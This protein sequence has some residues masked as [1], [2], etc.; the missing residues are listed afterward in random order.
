MWK[1]YFNNFL[2]LYIPLLL[3]SLLMLIGQRR[4]RIADFVAKEALV[5]MQKTTFLSDVCHYLIHNI[6]YWSG[7]VYPVGFETNEGHA[8]FIHPYIEVIK[9]I[10]FYDQFR[11]IDLSGEERLR[12]QSNFGRKMELSSLQNKVDSDYVLRGLNLKKGEVYLSR[13]NLNRENN[14]IERP[15][16][17]VLRAVAPIYDSL[18]TKVGLVVINFRVKD[19][20]DYLTKFPQYGK[21][22]LVDSELNVVASSMGGDLPPYEVRDNTEALQN[23]SD[24]G[25]VGIQNRRD[26][27]FYE[28]GS[29]WSYSN[30]RMN[31]GYL[32]Q[33]GLYSKPDRIVNETQWAIVRELPANQIQMGLWPLYQNFIVLQLISIL[34]LAGISYGYVK[35]QTQKKD[36]YGQLKEKNKALLHNQK[37]LKTIN[38]LVRRTNRRLNIRNEQLEQFSY[39]ISHNLRSPVTSMS[40]IVDIIKKEKDPEN[41]KSLLPKLHKLSDSIS[42]LTEDIKEYIAVVDQ[43]EPHLQEVNIYALLQGMKNEFPEIMSGKENFEIVYELEEWKTI[44]S[45]RYCLQSIFHNLISNAIRFRRPDVASYLIFRSGF[46]NGRKVLFVEDN[47][48]GIDMDRYGEDVFKLYKRFHRSI[49]GKG[50]GLFLVK[51]QLE[52]INATISIK[53][54]VGKGSIFQIN[55]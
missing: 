26:T 32:I 10:G 42:C 52:A 37:S 43:K 20:L 30:V 23:L 15:F 35:Y 36:L 44:T 54:I 40:L 8:D 2:L 28:N 14:E 3:I 12:Y 13:I 51:T 48:L 39:L 47:G 19:I 22:Y 34:T 6:N 5:S 46:E 41:V 7:I 1:K 11:I 38:E 53:S 29:V 33:S 18:D 4:E 17:P 50:M 16:K 9:N 49:S 31:N 24:V 21:T 45:S 27:T 55:F 25:V